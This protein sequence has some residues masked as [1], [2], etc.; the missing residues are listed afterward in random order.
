MLY[1]GIAGILFLVVR[2]IGSYAMDDIFGNMVIAWAEAIAWIFLLLEFVVRY[3]YRT[4]R[5]PC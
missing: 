4:R 5:K 3:W 1:S 2:I